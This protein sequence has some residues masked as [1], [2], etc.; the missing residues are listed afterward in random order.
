MEQNVERPEMKFRKKPP[1]L[2]PRE[3]T[4]KEKSA[5]FQ[6]LPEEREDMAR[7]DRLFSG[8]PVRAG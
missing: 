2:N 7:G 8:T 5:R 6:G 1:R 4:D 3:V